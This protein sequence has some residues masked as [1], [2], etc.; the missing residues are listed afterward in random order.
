M[1][2][3]Q[4]GPHDELD[5]TNF[6][7]HG[8]PKGITDE[9]WRAAIGNR[10]WKLYHGVMDHYPCSTCR[11]A[12]LVLISGIHDIVNIHLG[13]GVYDRKS[14][15]KFKGFVKLAIAQDH[16]GGHKNYRSVK[17]KHIQEI[18]EALKDD[19]HIVEVVQ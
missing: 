18:R 10:T 3:I 11:E 17:S 7:E 8:I 13:K 14:W 9:E 15:N 16:D 2:H 6:F 12:G 4:E 19:A 1:P 5:Y